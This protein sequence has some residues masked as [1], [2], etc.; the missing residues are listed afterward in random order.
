MLF[1]TTQIDGRGRPTEDRILIRKLMEGCECFAV[2]DGHSGNAVVRMTAELLPK[3]IE[4][5]LVAAG[6]DVLRTPSQIV[7]ILRTAFLEHDKELARSGKAS[8]SGSTASVALVTDTHIIMAYLGDSPAF[9]M[10]PL[11]GLIRSEIGKHEPTQA[12]ETE[13]ITAAGGTVEIDEYGTPRVDGSLMVSRAFGDFSLKYDDRKPPPFEADWTRF[14]VTA[15][16]D[17]TVWSRPTVGV[18]AIMSDGFVETDSGIL[19]P[20]AAVAKDIMEALK[21]VNMNLQEAAALAAKRHVIASVKG[22]SPKTYD[23]DD[24]SMVL[25]DVGSQHAAAA[26]IGGAA[27]QRAVAAVAAA[28]AMR[29]KTR[30]AHKGRRN[31]TG[32]KARIIKILTA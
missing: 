21:G 25:V 32:K 22:A 5:A 29:P 17:V 3:R 18:L 11:T 1:G 6:P 9:L 27:A 30:H 4:A 7:Q 26:Q 15:Y 12:K 19:K 2:F 14:K 31:K 16:P 23:G 20:T 10:D 24:L 28:A 13:R 8:D